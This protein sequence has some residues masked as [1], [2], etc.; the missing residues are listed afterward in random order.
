MSL[1]ELFKADL[2]SLAHDGIHYGLSTHEEI[3]EYIIKRCQVELG[4]DNDNFYTLKRLVLNN[5]VDI[6]ENWEEQKLKERPSGE[7]QKLKQSNLYK[8]L[9]QK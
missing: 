2:T 8:M 3:K 7:W 1:K 5:E 9:M 6:D 4:I